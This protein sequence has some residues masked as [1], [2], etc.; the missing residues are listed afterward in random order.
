MGTRTQPH[1]TFTPRLASLRFGFAAPCALITCEAPGS[2]GDAAACPSASAGRARTRPFSRSRSHHRKAL[3]RCSAKTC[4]CGPRTSRLSSSFTPPLQRL[5]GVHGHHQQVLRAGDA[6]S[7]P[8]PPIH[9]S[10]RFVG[11]AARRRCSSAHSAGGDCT[12]RGV[13]L[14]SCIYIGHREIWTFTLL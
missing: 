6:D 3:R 10:A 9:V 4:L 14:H 1:F 7:L 12:G 2:R 13:S 5:V 8:L 11:L